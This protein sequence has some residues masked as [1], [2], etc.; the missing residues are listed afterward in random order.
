MK[1]WLDKSQVE[2][3]KHSKVFVMDI[4][5]IYCPFLWRPFTF[6]GEKWLKFILRTV[7]HNG[8]LSLRS[9]RAVCHLRKS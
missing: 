1:R 6:D 2:K 8:A 5:D 9:H 7:F 4:R 3:E